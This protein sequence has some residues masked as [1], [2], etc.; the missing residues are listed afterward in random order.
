MMKMVQSVAG[1][2]LKMLTYRSF[3]IWLPRDHNVIKLLV[4]EAHD[5]IG[6]IS[7][8][9]TLTELR[10]T[11]WN[12]CGREIARSLTSKCVICK[13]LEGLAFRG[14]TVKTRIKEPIFVRTL[15]LKFNI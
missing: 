7:L 4:Y 1:V 15:R 10:S 14:T 2:E 3:P 6:H 11:F 9:E 5:K 12:V 8:R 13:V